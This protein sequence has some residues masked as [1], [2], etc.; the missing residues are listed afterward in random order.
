MIA[1][2]RLEEVAALLTRMLAEAR[3]LRRIA[4]A[5]ERVVAV[6]GWKLYAKRVP[7]VLG[8]SELDI[9]RALEEIK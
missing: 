4:A 2:D 3:Q 1:N 5:V 7:P 8:P 6:L 9:M